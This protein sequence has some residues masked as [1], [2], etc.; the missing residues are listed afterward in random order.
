MPSAPCTISLHSKHFSNPPIFHRGKTTAVFQWRKQNG[1]NSLKIKK[2]NNPSGS[3]EAELL[4]WDKPRPV[5]PA[6]QAEVG[7]RG[8]NDAV[9]PGGAEPPPLRGCHRAERAFCCSAT[10]NRTREERWRGTRSSGENKKNYMEHIGRGASVSSS[11]LDPFPAPGEQ[12]GCSPV[13]PGRMSHRCPALWHF[14]GSLLS[15]WVAIKRWNC[16]SCAGEELD[17]LCP[18]GALQAGCLPLGDT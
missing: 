14:L 6:F 15:Q 5:A 3:F 1:K 9:L 18:P 7:T 17:W 16:R 13:C 12:A 8:M 4:A 10:T 2:Q 11:P